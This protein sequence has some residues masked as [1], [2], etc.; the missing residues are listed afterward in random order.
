VP[1]AHK[2]LDLKTGNLSDPRRPN[3]CP[4]GRWRGKGCEREKEEAEE[5]QPDAHKAVPKPIAATRGP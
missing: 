5:V 2:K 3:A 4:M 1:P